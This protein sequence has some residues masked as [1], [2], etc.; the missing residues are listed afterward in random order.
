MS[1][2]S[3][4]H[5]ASSSLKKYDASVPVI[6]EESGDVVGLSMLSDEISAQWSEAVAS[7]CISRNETLEDMATKDVKFALLPFYEARA[8]CLSI[9]GEVKPPAD[10]MRLLEDAK[11]WYTLFFDMLS[12]LEI[13]SRAELESL[14]KD[15]PRNPSERRSRLIEKLRQEK[16]ENAKIEGL[17]RKSKF[18]DPEV[19]E[20]IEREVSVSVL[21]AAA[22]EAAKSRRSLDEEIQLLNYAVETK[23]EG[24]DPAEEARKLRE[25]MPAPESYRIMDTRKYQQDQV[26][27]PSHNLPTYT[28]EEWGEIELARMRE[29]MK[30]NAEKEKLKAEESDEDSDKDEVSDR[31]TMKERAWADWTDDNNKGSGNT[32]R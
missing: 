31:K 18:A 17:K 7:G 23:A 28:V 21:K 4:F 12:T 1:L 16:E 24:K 26:F 9:P 11:N 15:L 14:S 2:S 25:S 13:V 27:K 3:R 19:A 32:I 10:R 20:E 8:L 29:Q 6:G 5:A 30:I 22:R